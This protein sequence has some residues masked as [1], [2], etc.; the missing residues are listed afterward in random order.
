MGSRNRATTNTCGRYQL[1]QLAAFSE[2]KISAGNTCTDSENDSGTAGYGATTT[3]RLHVECTAPLGRFQKANNS[4]GQ[5]CSQVRQ[6]GI[7]L[8]GTSEEDC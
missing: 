4:K 2:G 3:T 6:G 8:T 5:S 1:L 7:I